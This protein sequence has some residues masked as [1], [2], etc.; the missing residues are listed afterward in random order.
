MRFP[1]EE[2]GTSFERRG[3]HD[4]IRHFGDP[5]GEYRAATEGAALRDRGHRAQW[6][7]TGKQP[8]EMLKGIVTGVTPGLPRPEE[9]GVLV[10]RGTYHAVLTPKGKMLADL[11]LWLEPG[12]E[13]Q[14][15]VRAHLPAEAA[16]P[17]R[18]HLAK[19]LPPRLARL[20]DRSAQLGMIS[21][22]GPEASRLVSASVLGLRVERGELDGMAEDEFRLLPGGDGDDLLV[23]RNG[24]LSV[25]AFDIVGDRGA[26]RSLWRL[27]VEAGA[28]PTGLQ[29][30]DAL[31][32]E[33]G[34]PAFG[35]ELGPD[36]IPV[37]AGIHHRAIDYGKGCYTGQEVIVRIRDRGHVNR[38]LRRLILDLDAPLPE[39][40]TAL[41]RDG[42][43]AVGSITTA[44]DSPR[45]GKLALAYLRRAVEPG[46]TV[47]VG[48]PDGPR[49][50]VES[51][52]DD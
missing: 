30:W 11:L 49:A 7:F 52:P 14:A 23:L 50:R 25:P 1:P 51:L 10:G 29:V 31:R 34:R 36:V 4:I 48:S 3:A 33:R 6:T 16:G 9:L 42:E 24:S 37:E 18:D 46:Q 5:E 38:N 26:L 40:G 47:H 13:G 17:L 45:K 21:L 41:F 15:V 35:R 39:P 2:S 32:L 22:V 28:E 12:A 27:L 44:A 19:V 43:K 20:E 8:L